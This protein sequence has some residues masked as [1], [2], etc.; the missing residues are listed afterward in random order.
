V[1]LSLPSSPEP[2]FRRA[3]APGETSE[4][5]LYLNAGADDVATAGPAGGPVRLRV[6]GGPGLDRLDEAKSGGTRFYDSDGRSVVAG[7]GTH[8]DGKA[9]E[10]RPAKP[11]ETPWLEWRDWGKR[12]RPVYQVWWEPDP[13]V[14]L[15]A[16]LTRQGWGFR[17]SPYASLQ[18]AQLQYSVGRNDF[19]L[20]YDGEFRRENSN[21]YFVVDAQASQLENLNY[22]GFGNDTA[23]APPEG[24]EEDYFDAASN[25]YD[26]FLSGWWAPA[27]TLHLFAGP[28]A[29]VTDTPK[30]QTGSMGAEQPYGIGTFGQAGVRAGFDLDTRGH[31]LTGTF[32]D[33]FRADDKPALSGVRLKAEGFYYADAWD[34]QGFG[35]V[36]ATLRGYLVGRRAM[37][38]ARIGGRRV[39]GE[40]PWFEAAFV[41]G[42]K[43]LR[44]FRKN[45]FAGDASLYGSVEARVWLFRG[46]LFAPGRWGAFGLV[47]AGRVF[48]DGESSDTWHESYGGGIFF[49]MLTLNTVIHASAAHGD[50]GTR[51]HVGYGFGF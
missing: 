20:N 24:Q 29:K 22:F 49:Q 40:Y 9:W 48:L 7:P 28:D 13:G 38:A 36:E 14:M 19:K 42:G 8:V 39:F 3:F 26:L 17:K 15:A 43:S 32:G 34:A 47:D 46:R 33:Q 6:V 41:G 1:A 21:V 50:E 45:R 44:S 30:N 5:R 27:R 25:T 10:R 31:K 51:F 2:W 35:G 11:A 18:A 23:S 16:G 12:T 37:L 4:V